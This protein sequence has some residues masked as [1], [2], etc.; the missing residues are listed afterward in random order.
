MSACWIFRAFPDLRQGT[1][2]RGDGLTRLFAPFQYEVQG[3]IQGKEFPE[4]FVIDG[5]FDE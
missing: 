3:C 2:P 1:R 4:G 5:E